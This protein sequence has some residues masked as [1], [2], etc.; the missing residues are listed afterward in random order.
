MSPTSTG[1]LYST[2]RLVCVPI[3][4][5][6]FE[7]TEKFSFEQL[8]RNSDM[9]SENT[10]T[11]YSYS[12]NFFSLTCKHSGFVEVQVKTLECL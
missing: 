9:S 5:V 12:S 3:A 11:H 10:H 1:E 7:E 6:R 2:C 4:C 8:E